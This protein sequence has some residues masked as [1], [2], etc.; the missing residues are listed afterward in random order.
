MPRSQGP[1]RPYRGP[2]SERDLRQAA[3]SVWPGQARV[4][5]DGERIVQAIRQDRQRRNKPSLAR[6]L[7]SRRALIPV[8][9]GAA[10]LGA[11]G[12]YALHQHRKS[13]KV[14]KTLINPFEETVVFGKAY[15]IAWPPQGETVIRALVPTGRHV[16]HAN[17]LTHVKGRNSQPTNRLKHVRRKGKGGGLGT[18]GKSAPLVAVEVRRLG[19]AFG[20]QNKRGS[21]TT[22]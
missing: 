3:S 10:T 5:A 9:A 15:P 8:A 22:R 16:S 11:G 18:V 19:Q 13:R 21:N 17:K 2:R 12:G 20:N 7:L 1:R 14:E 4:D 6:S